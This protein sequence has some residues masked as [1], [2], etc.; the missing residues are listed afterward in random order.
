MG[1]L[2]QLDVLE[3]CIPEGYSQKSVLKLKD[4]S[5]MTLFSKAIKVPGMGLGRALW[6]PPVWLGGFSQKLQMGMM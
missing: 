1:T 2:N 4:N 6:V 5:T 3:K